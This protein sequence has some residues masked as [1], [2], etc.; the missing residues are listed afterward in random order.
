MTHQCPKCPISNSEVIKKESSNSPQRP[1][2]DS[3]D[4]KVSQ[5]GCGIKKL[6]VAGRDLCQGSRQTEQGSGGSSE[7]TKEGLRVAA[8]LPLQRSSPYSSSSCASNAASG[9]KEDAVA[10]HMQ[11]GCRSRSKKYLNL[12]IF[13]F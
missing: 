11:G 12:V 10:V 6:E 9:G 4:P 8:D 3:S 1:K 7:T 13:E 2:I 5:N